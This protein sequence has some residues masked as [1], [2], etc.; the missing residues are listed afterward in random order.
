MSES[1]RQLKF[2]KLIKKDISEILHREYSGKF[3][4]SLVSVSDVSM[5]PDLG[6]ARIYLSIFPVSQTG[7]VME[8]LNS[9]KSRLRGALGRRIGKQVRIVPELALFDD[10]TAEEASNMDRLIDSLVIP[11]ETSEDQE[12]TE[13][14]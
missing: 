12:D 3:A 6:L 2:A 8:M 13:E 7:T 4:G 1:Q 5:S 10:K 9:E 11:P 14:S